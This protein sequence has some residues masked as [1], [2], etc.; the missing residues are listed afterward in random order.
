[1]VNR[2]PKVYLGKK[3]RLADEL[4]VG[5]GGRSVHY[6]YTITASEVKDIRW[7]DR[8]FMEGD[9]FAECGEEYVGGGVTEK[10]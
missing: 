9:A 7:G 1:M 3:R 4:R 10:S 5:P 6:P 2:H 8:E